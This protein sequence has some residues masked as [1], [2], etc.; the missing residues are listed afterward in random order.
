MT[1]VGIVLAQV[2]N[3]FACRSDRL[4]ITR[5]GWFTNPLIM[6]GI[7]TE[8]ILL[9]LITYTPIGNDI[10]GTSPL[11][12]WIYGQLA[13]GALVLLL[14]EE[15]RKMIVNRHRRRMNVGMA[16]ISSTS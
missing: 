15:G 3:V 9:T 1:F 2:A 10:F 16:R 12:L 6:W 5:L 7:F 13:L 14:A 11:P 8:L 4:S